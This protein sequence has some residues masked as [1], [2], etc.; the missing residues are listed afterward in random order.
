MKMI[1]RM[2]LG[3]G[4]VLDVG[5]MLTVS[6][7]DA[8]V[9][10][11]VVSGVGD[12]KLVPIEMSP[13]SCWLVGILM[14]IPFSV[15]GDVVELEMTT[16]RSIVVGFFA[17]TEVKIGFGDGKNAYERLSDVLTPF[18]KRS[19]QARAGRRSVWRDDPA[20]DGD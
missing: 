13:L 9:Q 5:T 18:M 6:F 4:G 1:G 3:S 10:G 16:W 20:G 15:I 14:L 11:P 17:D 12:G 7:F 8:M 19:L 2:M